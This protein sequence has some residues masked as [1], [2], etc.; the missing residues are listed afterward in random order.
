MLYESEITNSSI[1]TLKTLIYNN[2]SFPS[3]FLN[4]NI[5]GQKLFLEECLCFDWSYLPLIVISIII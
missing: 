5:V 4:R 1:T 3:F 2:V